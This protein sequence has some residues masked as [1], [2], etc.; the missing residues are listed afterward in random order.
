MFTIASISD[1]VILLMIF[2]YIF[3][4]LGMSFFAGQIKFDPE[5]NEPDPING[6]SPRN[7][8]DDLGWALVAVF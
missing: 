2:I 6:I 3:A 4:L 5:T 8:F 7:N 1:Y